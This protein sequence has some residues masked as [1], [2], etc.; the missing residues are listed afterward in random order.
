[1]ARALFATDLRESLIGPVAF[2]RRGDLENAPVAIVV[3]RRGGGSDQ[4]LSTE[5]ASFLAVR[6]NP[7][8][9]P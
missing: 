3:A 8:P 6:D 1:M 2:D 5:G 9:V 4:V 7:P